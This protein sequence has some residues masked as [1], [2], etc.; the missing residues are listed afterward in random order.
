MVRNELLKWIW[1]S[2]ALGGANDATAPLLD[3]FGTA[4]A[5][6][7]TKQKKFSCVPEMKW[8]TRRALSKKSLSR[9]AQILDSCEQKGINILV[10]TDERFPEL[11]RTIKNPPVLLYY[12]GELPDLNRRL[13]LAAVGTRSMS[14]YGMTSAYK[15]SYDLTRAG[16]LIVSGMALGIDGVCAA[17][18]LAA[19]GETVAV[20]GCGIDVLYPKQHR[21]LC[22]EICRHGVIVSEYP[23]STL[24]LAR[25]F[26]ERNRLISGMCCATLAFEGGEDSGAMITARAALAEKRAVYALPG[27]VDKEGSRGMNLLL[28]EGALP[29]LSAKDIIYRYRYTHRSTSIN[30]LHTAEYVEPLLDTEQ[31]KSLG[32][33]KQEKRKLRKT[34]ESTYAKESAAPARE[35]EAEPPS[36]ELLSSLPPI[37]AEILRCIYACKD[38]ASADDIYALPY[39]YGELSAAMTQMEIRGLIRR[40]PGSMIGRG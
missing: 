18:A 4:E 32:V 27:D 39:S 3:A 24:P 16:A 21:V 10:Y 7:D 2:L 8:G 13:C 20:L 38:H 25:H 9:A 29:L 30:A 40:L 12:R 14:E 15:I 5:I 6:Y 35:K 19:G 11:L 31:L 22:E 33:L 28:D 37:Q 23:P 17:A 34:E 26:P 1:L 36:E